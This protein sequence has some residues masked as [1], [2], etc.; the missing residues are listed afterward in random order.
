M[1]TITDKEFGV[2]LRERPLYSK[3]L[4]TEEF[5]PNLNTYSYPTDFDDKSIKFYC[6]KDKDY[7]TFK[8]NNFSFGRE[9]LRPPSINMIIEQKLPPFWDEQTKILD[10]T[11][12]ISGECQMCGHKIFFLLNITSDGAFDITKNLLPNIFIQKV[13]QIPPFEIKPEKEILN[14][15]VK[16]DKKNYSKALANLSISYG[17]GAFAYFRRIIENEIKRLIIDIIDLEENS[18]LELRNA[19]SKYQ[20][21]HQMSSLISALSEY[22][23]DSFQVIGDN[24]V[25]LLHDQLSGGIHEFSDEIC[26]EKAVNIDTLLRFTIKKINEGKVELRDVRNAINN[27]KNK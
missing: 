16:E 23:P 22:L 27:L 13:G 20:E 15:L 25:K 4:V 21:N 12:P 1:K 6:E 9:R 8:C 14:Y 7:Q 18:S 5:E 3:I 11:L 24:P 26:L 19:H 17:I 10:L 2:F